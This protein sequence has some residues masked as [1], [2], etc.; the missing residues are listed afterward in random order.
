MSPIDPLEFVDQIPT[1]SSY[2][3][4]L[5][6][7]FPHEQQVGN[8]FSAIAERALRSLTFFP[9]WERR[10]ER[11]NE[12]M[13]AWTVKDRA[14]SLWNIGRRGGANHRPTRRARGWIRRMYVG[15]ANPETRV[16]TRQRK[17][18]CQG[19]MEWM[20]HEVA[21]RFASHLAQVPG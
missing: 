20:H 1:Q 10:K 6:L 3:C 9:F 14:R 8:C 13:Y 17:A 2:L 4:W 16:G 18:A 21:S 19:Q 11:T 7:L 12:R 15:S 5:F